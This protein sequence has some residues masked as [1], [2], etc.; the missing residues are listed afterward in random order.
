ME[1]R[2][3]WRLCEELLIVQAALLIAGNDPSVDHA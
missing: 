1:S 3:Y 2:D